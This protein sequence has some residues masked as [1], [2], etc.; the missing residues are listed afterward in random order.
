M[1]HQ[2]R[3][4]V[5]G[6]V[7]VAIGKVPLEF[8]E[9]ALAPPTRMNLPRSPPGTLVLRGAEFGKFRSSWDG[10]P[11]ITEKCS[12]TELSLLPAGIERQNAFAHQHLFCALNEQMKHQDWE[13]WAEKLSLVH[14]DEKMANYVIQQS[15]DWLAKREARKELRRQARHAEA[16]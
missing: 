11:S 8:L 16:S 15:K 14:Y 2:I 1:L 4:M 12:G 9:A 10:K 3:H 7:L 6:A 5:G 13:E